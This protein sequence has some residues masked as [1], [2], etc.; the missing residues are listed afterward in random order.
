MGPESPRSCLL[1][2]VWKSLL[3]L[4]VSVVLLTTFTFVLWVVATHDYRWGA[5]APYPHKLFSGWLTTLSIS[6]ASLVLSV[7]V[8]ALLTAGGGFLLSR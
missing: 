2:A 4:F 7:L 3:S 6:G 8:A 5:I 1:F